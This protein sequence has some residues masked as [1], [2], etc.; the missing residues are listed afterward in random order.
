[1][2]DYNLTIDPA[3]GYPTV[4]SCKQNVFGLYYASPDV[5]SAFQSL[6]TDPDLQQAFTEYWATVAKTVAGNP[7][8]VGMD[9]FNEPFA[10][11]FWRDLTR[12]LP[13]HGD[14]NYLQ[15]LYQQVHQAVRQVDDTRILFFECKR[16]ARYR[17]YRCQTQTNLLCWIICSSQPHLYPM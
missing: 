8:V 1:M 17:T 2:K 5:A 9:M 15:P 3:T 11:N 7:Y 13:G 10:G 12:I 6:Y 14:K 4:E 16:F